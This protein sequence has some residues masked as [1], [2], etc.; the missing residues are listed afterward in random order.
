[1]QLVIPEDPDYPTLEIDEQFL[2]GLV[3]TYG[4]EAANNIL[5]DRNRKIRLAKE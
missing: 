4:I 3:E 5:K 1:M 2:R